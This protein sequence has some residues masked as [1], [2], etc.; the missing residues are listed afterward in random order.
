MVIRHF[1]KC[2]L[3][4]IFPHAYDTSICSAAWFRRRVSLLCS[5]SI[6]WYACPG[7][8]FQYRKIELKN[9]QEKTKLQDSRQIRKA[10]EHIIDHFFI[11]DRC[12]KQ[13]AI[14]PRANNTRICKR[15]CLKEIAILISGQNS[16]GTSQMGRGWR[17]EGTSQLDLHNSVDHS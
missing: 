10:S 7:L 9:S 14:R 15:P 4:I 12:D 8:E 13:S 3:L 16:W 1:L 6:L 11:Y 2:K 17:G 5:S